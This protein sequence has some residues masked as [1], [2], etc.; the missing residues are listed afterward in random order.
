MLKYIMLNGDIVC[1]NE[2]RNAYKSF[3]DIFIDF[4][5]GT[6][7]TLR[8]TYFDFDRREKDFLELCKALKELSDGGTTNGTM[9]G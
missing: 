8:I 6:P 2:I 7:E 9:V 4:K 3:G 1:V 5:C